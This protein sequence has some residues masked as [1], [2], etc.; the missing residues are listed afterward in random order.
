M[1]SDWL[2]VLKLL[3]NWWSQKCWEK[4]S[5]VSTSCSLLTGHIGAENA[6]E[7]LFNLIVKQLEG[8]GSYAWFLYSSTYTMLEFNTIQP[9]IF[10]RRL[11]Q[12]DLNT[13]LVPWIV[14][15]KRTQRVEINWVLSAQVAFSTGSPTRMYAL[16]LV[17]YPVHQY[18]SEQVWKQSHFKVSRWL[19]Y[20]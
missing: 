16:A 7:T 19:Y 9:C 13:N 4:P 6:K 15:C 5:M 2:P 20:C 14:N 8:N 18:M 12:L 11:E 3:E 10:V 1:I 17:I